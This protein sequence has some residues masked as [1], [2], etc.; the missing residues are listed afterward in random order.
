[1]GLLEDVVLKHSIE[2]RTTPEKIFEFFR[3]LHLGDNYQKWHPEDHVLIRWVEGE[4]W[5][6]GSIVYAEQYA[7]GKL[8]K[9]KYIVMK[10]VPN[11]EIEFSPLFWLWRIYFP[12]NTFSIEPRG[13]TSVFTAAAHLRVGWLVKKLARKKFEAAL[14]S[15]RQHISEEG[16]NLKRLLENPAA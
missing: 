11:R 13:E 12:K 16:K 7:H 8:H 6:E 5:E 9:L 14:E 4:P 2:I 3:R 1:M 10:L 15:G